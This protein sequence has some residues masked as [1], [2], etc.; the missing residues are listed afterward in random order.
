MARADRGAAR[1]RAPPSTGRCGSSARAAGS[2]QAVGRGGSHNPSPRAVSA[3]HPPARRAA[4]RQWEGVRAAR[5]RRREKKKRRTAPPPWPCTRGGGGN[6]EAERTEGGDGDHPSTRSPQQGA[7]PEQTAC[8]TMDRKTQREEE[9][10]VQATTARRD[11]DTLP[12]MTNHPTELQYRKGSLDTDT[13]AEDTLEHS[14]DGNDTGCGRR[15]PR[16]WRQ[17]QKNSAVS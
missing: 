3:A 7:V 15:R 4:P 13:A 1:G 9:R 12:T 16:R 2:T 17:T 6:W 14:A 11:R 5:G 8:S 10:T